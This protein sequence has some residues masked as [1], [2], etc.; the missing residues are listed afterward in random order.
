[1]TDITAGELKEKH[2]LYDVA[3]IFTQWSDTSHL[4]AVAFDA[5]KKD[6]AEDYGGWKVLSFDHIPRNELQRTYSSVGVAGAEKQLAAPGSSTWMPQL[7]PTIYNYDPSPNQSNQQRPNSAG[8]IGSL[9]LLFAL[10][11]FSAPPLQLSH[12]LTSFMQPGRWLTHQLPHGRGSYPIHCMDIVDRQADEEQ[13]GMVV[14]VFLDPKHPKGST[15]PLLDGLRDG[16]WGPF[17]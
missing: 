11:A 9:P 8:L 2:T 3:T 5:E 1:M 14:T 7:L 15:K 6:V 4:L 16:Y 10:P 12:V 17:Y 13:R